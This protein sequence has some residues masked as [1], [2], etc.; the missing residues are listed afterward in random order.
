MPQQKT[1]TSANFHP[2]SKPS[3]SSTMFTPLE[4]TVE[5]NDRACGLIANEEYKEAVSLLLDALAECKPAIVQ[6]ETNDAGETAVKSEVLIDE[7]MASSLADQQQEGRGYSQQGLRCMA[8]NASFVYRWPIAVR[9]AIASRVAP[10]SPLSSVSPLHQQQL[11][12][13]AIDS[14]PTNAIL[15]IAVVFNLAIAH[16]LHAQE[17]TPPGSKQE[18]LLNRALKLYQM[19][20]S[21]HTKV[22]PNSVSEQQLQ[23][24]IF[25]LATC[26]NMG[27]VYE[28]L[29]YYEGA[30]AFYDQVLNILLQQHRHSAAVN[31]SLR[32]H[33]YHQFQP[34]PLQAIPTEICTLFLYNVSQSTF[35]TIKVAAAA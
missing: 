34:H 27:A 25:V 16:Q 12:M 2:G 33:G 14:C 29:G 24:G 13:T 5:K 10:Q 26:N 20:Y 11:N 22:R 23:E 31:E 9:T 18:Y 21:L 15:S 28:L 30:R 3:P 32:T 17:K 8:E 7:I 35:R 19:A 6:I 4:S 1:F